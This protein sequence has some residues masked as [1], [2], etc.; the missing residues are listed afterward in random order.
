MTLKIDADISVIDSLSKFVKANIATVSQVFDSGFFIEDFN[1]QALP[2]RNINHNN[3]ESLVHFTKNAEHLLE[4]AKN[5][6]NAKTI[7]NAIIYAP[8]SCM[9]WHTNSDDPGTRIY[10]S[11]TTKLSIFR[12]ID[13]T[14]GQI[15]DDIDNI[16]WTARR[17]DITDESNPLW[18]T[19]WTSGIR[20]SF[21][22]KL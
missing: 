22:F 16:G 17:F 4:Y 20:F 10:Y 5:T 14:T 6:V 1:N 3:T 12:Y 9:T 8:N 11:Y 19:I 13:K 15:V 7:T 18:H 21:G 2:D